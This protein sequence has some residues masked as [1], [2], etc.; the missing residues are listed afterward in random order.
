MGKWEIEREINREFNRLSIDAEKYEP[1]I[2]QFRNNKKDDNRNYVYISEKEDLSSKGDY[3]VV[4]VYNKDRF[5][6]AEIV[7]TVEDHEDDFMQIVRST[8]DKLFDYDV[9]Y[10]RPIAFNLGKPQYGYMASYY[11]TIEKLERKVEIEKLLEE[12]AQKASIIKK[13][14]SLAPYDKDIEDL[15]KEYKDL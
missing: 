4:S 12:K 9:K 1:V 8:V 10:I 11:E 3:V 13:Y 7:Q 2:V 15:L 6:V 5:T 14:E